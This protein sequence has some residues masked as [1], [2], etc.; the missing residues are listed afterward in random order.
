MFSV[1]DLFSKYIFIYYFLLK[2][3][4]L[5]TTVA[6]LTTLFNELITIFLKSF[7]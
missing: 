2:N 5:S 1:V 7:K 6:S 3:K 4:K